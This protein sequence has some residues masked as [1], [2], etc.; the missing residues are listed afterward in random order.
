MLI[1]M[2]VYLLRVPNDDSNIENFKDVISNIELA[3]IVDEKTAGSNYIDYKV[4]CDDSV[5]PITFRKT[6]SNEPG[7]TILSED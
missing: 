5:D 4:D 1:I 6:I 3:E 2:S 7:M